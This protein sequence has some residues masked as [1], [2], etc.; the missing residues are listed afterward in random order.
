MADSSDNKKNNKSGKK[1]YNFG[2]IKDCNLEQ[3]ENEVLNDSVY[4]DVFAGSDIRS[5]LTKCSSEILSECS[6]S[7]N[8]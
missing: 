4:L 2:G 5:Y 8:F 1:D 3:I 6:F 7:S